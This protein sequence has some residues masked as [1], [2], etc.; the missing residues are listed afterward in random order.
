MGVRSTLLFS[1]ILCAIVL[2]SGAMAV[3]VMGASADAV[4]NGV[5]SSNSDSSSTAASAIVVGSEHTGRGASDATGRLG[6]SAEFLGASGTTA[7]IGANATYTDTFDYVTGSST[8]DFFIP[9]AAIGFEA[10]NVPG[11][12]G[13]FLVEVFL[14]GVNIF[15]TGSTVE[16]IAGTP[17]DPADLLLTQSGTLLTS[18]FDTGI[19]DSFGLGGAG[20]RFNPFSGS[21]DVSPLIG[22][23][24]I[25]Y[26]MDARVNGLI[27]ETSAIA[28]IG[29]PLNLSQQPAGVTLTVNSGTAPVPEPGTLALLIAGIVGMGF[30]KRGIA[31]GEFR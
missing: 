8:F 12:T 1:T 14:N 2:S 11:L 16:T 26:S 24:T 5:F 7:S 22:T 23:N 20:Y 25:S 15:T 6:V 4:L 28:S 31:S 19:A 21:L 13:S 17:Q 10:N 30:S 9:S 27:G 3:P 18:V 29:D